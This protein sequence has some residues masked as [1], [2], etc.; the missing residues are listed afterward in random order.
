MKTIILY[1]TKYGAT[2]DIAKRIGSKIEDSIIHNLKEKLPALD[3][4]DC[5]IFGSPVYAGAIRREAKAFLTQNA[6]I[7][8]GK[9]FG[10]F[11]CG[12]GAEN[13]EAYFNANFSPELLEKAKEKDFFGGIFDPKKANVFERLIIKLITK[14]SAYINLISGRKIEKF[15]EAIKA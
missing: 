12:L 10:L 15:T 13:K 8:T 3:N 6:N 11:L 14:K 7:L 4:F 1:A 9:K 2:E 5:I